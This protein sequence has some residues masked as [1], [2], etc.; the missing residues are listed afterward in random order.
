MAQIEKL[1]KVFSSK[2]ILESAEMN[3]IT[4]K[5]DEIITSVNSQGVILGES[6]ALLDEL[7]GEVV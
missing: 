1:N 6:V 3:T 5:I 4:A 7:N 2:Q